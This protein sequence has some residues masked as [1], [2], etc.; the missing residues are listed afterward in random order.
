MPRLLSLLAARIGSL[1]NMS[2][3]SR[4]SGIPNST[5]KRYLSLLRAT[6]LFQPLSAWA[7][8]RGKRLIKSPEIHLIDPGLTAHL[9]GA[10]RQSLDRDPVFIGHLLENLVVNELRKQKGWS[11]NRIELFHSVQQPVGR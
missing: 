10:T 3:L 2:E 5:L 1:L 11:D 7:S 6:F 8:N 9:S 4:S